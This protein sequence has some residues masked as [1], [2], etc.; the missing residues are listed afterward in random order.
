MSKNILI[1]GATGSIGAKLV[2]TILR[3]DTTTRVILLVR[4]ESEAK[5]LARVQG[6]LKI[7]SPELATSDFSGR[8][9]IVTGDITRNKL[10][11]SDSTYG[12][13]T[14]EVTDIIH[15]AAA[16]GFLTPLESAR[17]INLGGT[18]NVMTF[19]ARAA[20]R[21]RLRAI[22]HVSTAYVNSNCQQTIYEHTF[23]ERCEFLHS[24]DQTKWEAEQYVRGLMSSLPIVIF[25]PS[26]VVGDS[27]TGRTSAFN[28]LYTPLRF[29]CQGQVSVLPGYPD[30]KLDVVSSDYVADVIHHIFVRKSDGIGN[31]YQIVAGP[32]K[33]LTIDEI[34]KR[35]LN[36]AAAHLGRTDL[37]P[38]RW[39]PPARFDSLC[40]DSSN[41]LVR[42]IKIFQPYMSRHLRFD[43]T[44]TQTALRG[45]G[46]ELR[47]LA[48][49]FDTIIGYCLASNWGRRE[50]QAA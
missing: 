43:N 27:H 21:G 38:V 23:S 12:R 39:L 1:T 35:T 7:V 33:S 9:G 36:H 2:A 10:G 47:H 41:R 42:M 17:E 6:S 13:L 34:V 15:S 29:I 14:S 11:V 25:R 3:G 32:D 26:V 22:A 44:H 45:S 18:R 16:T 30:V 8:I 19:A 20:D 28:V 37:A 40:G 46:I 5:A 24:Y 48:E 49:Y 50:R 4:G 31:T